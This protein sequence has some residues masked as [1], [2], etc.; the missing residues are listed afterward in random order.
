MKKLIFIITIIVLFQS[1]S[2]NKLIRDIPNLK[3]HLKSVSGFKVSGISISDKQKLEDFSISEALRITTA[4]A[5]N[6]LPIS[7]TVNVEVSNPSETKEN[8]A[9]NDIYI[10]SFPWKLFLN[11]KETISGKITDPIII[12]SRGN[13]KNIGLEISFNLID[14]FKNNSVSELA[15]LVF[16]IGGKNG[17]PKKLEVKTKPTFSTSFGDFVWPDEITIVSKE[18]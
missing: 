11:K 5:N 1:C 13:S 14:Y 8:E 7:F 3:Y 4:V 15:D 18:Y 16:G 17:S 12:P 2:I 6:D 10:K 9:Y